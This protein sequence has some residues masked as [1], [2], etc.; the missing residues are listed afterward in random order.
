MLCDIG[1]R[2]DEQDGRHGE[3][4]VFGKSVPGPLDV[5]EYVE[6]LF[7]VRVRVN[8]VGYGQGKFSLFTTIIVGSLGLL[9]SHTSNTIK[10]LRP[11][12]FHRIQYAALLTI[13]VIDPSYN[14]MSA[15]RH[16][17]WLRRKGNRRSL[18]GDDHDASTQDLRD[19]VS[20]DGS[21]RLQLL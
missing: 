8:G 5:G 20:E 21:E 13:R 19:L 17:V 16:D 7:E 18:P 15:T 2:E 12:Q 1:E 10:Q 14:I 4:H 9:E 11:H 3:H 6:G